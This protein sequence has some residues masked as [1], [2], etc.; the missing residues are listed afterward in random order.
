[1]SKNWVKIIWGKE[2]I[3]LNKNKITI[4]KEALTG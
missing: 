1:M 4:E 3:K 2:I